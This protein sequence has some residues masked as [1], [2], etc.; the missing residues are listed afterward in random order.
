[1]KEL[2]CVTHVKRNDIPSMRTVEVNGVEQWLGH[3]KDFTKNEY[4]IDFLPDDNRI[5]M[6]WVRLESGEEL[7]VHTHP[8]ESMILLCEGSA[9]TTGDVQTSMEAGDALLV[10]PGR[11]HGFK[12]GAPNGFWGLSIQFDSRGL[13]EVIEDPWAIFITELSENMYN[14]NVTEQLFARNDG[15]MER[16]DKHRLFALANKGL[17]DSKVARKR[18]LDCFQVWSNYFQKMVLSRV[19]TLN[20]SNYEELAWQHLIDELGHNR[21]LAKSRSNLEHIFDP[22]LEAACS[23]FS[24]KMNTLTDIEKVVLVHLVV[25]ASA[26]YFYKH[27]SPAMQDTDHQKHFTIHSAIDDDHVKM[28]YDFIRNCNITDAKSLFD[29]QHKGWSMLM[30][31]MNRIVDL[32]VHGSRAVKEEVLEQTRQKEFVNEYGV[33]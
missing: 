12:G 18:F 32:T 26:T 29:I 4:L 20:D 5:S 17:L 2:T 8:V 7:Q 14:G 23:W 11:L 33:A 21:E 9:E 19:T 10:P 31:V 24:F 30:T 27:I 13:Y 1:M 15:Y 22:V 28:G 16:F 25:E 6:A 3:V